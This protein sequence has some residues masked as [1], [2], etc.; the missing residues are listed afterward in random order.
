MFTKENREV[1]QSTVKINLE[2]DWQKVEILVKAL[3]D[4]C[5]TLKGLLLLTPS[6]DEKILVLKHEIETRLFVLELANKIM[7]FLVQNDVD[8]SSLA[9]VITSNRE[10][11]E[12]VSEMLKSIEDKK[13]G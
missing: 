5:L 12:K 13:T 8:Y 9:T 4:H 10:Y 1:L 11:V 2:L 3:G 7:P 6:R